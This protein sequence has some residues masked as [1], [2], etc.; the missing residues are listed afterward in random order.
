MRSGIFLL[1]K[2]VGVSSAK[3][4]SQLQNK[5]SREFP[6][7]EILKIG[8][9]GTLD[10][11]AT[12]LLVVLINKATK[13]ADS[14]QAGH[15]Q[16]SGKIRFGIKTD[17]DDITGSVL[18]KSDSIPSIAEVNAAATNFLG[19]IEQVPPAISAV[20][21]GGKA[22]YKLA[23]A[24]KSPELK[25]RVVHL[26]DLSIYETHAADFSFR[27][28]CSK[29]FYVRSFARDLGLRLGT[30]ACLSEL[31]REVSEPFKIEDARTLEDISLENFIDWDIALNRQGLRDVMVSEVEYNSLG[32]G[33]I[34][35]SLK[36][37]LP[38]L[39][40]TYRSGLVVYR[41][42]HNNRAGGVLRVAQDYEL[43]L[44]YNMQ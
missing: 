43:E 24:G 42:S 41:G 19:E 21:I 16:Y 9:S 28:K 7:F 29:G 44:V 10:P 3:A 12:G 30:L 32:Q 17:S 5:L 34:R 26:F 39:L 31:R 4:I 36:E 20:K 23:R 33:L 27:L 22:A 38:S 13:L 35:N 2:G 37:R 8:H 14:F 6:L 15:K 11:F 1:D 25:S 18:E 40:D